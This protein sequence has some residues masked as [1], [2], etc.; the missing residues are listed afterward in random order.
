[1]VRNSLFRALVFSCLV[2]LFAF[3]TAD[4]SWAVELLGDPGFELSTPNGT[5]PDSGVWKKAWYPLNAGQVCTSTAAHTGRSGLWEYTAD[6][7]GLS[8]SGI[9][10]KFQAVAGQKATGS[11]WVRTPPAGLG[12]SW[13]NGSKACVRLE[14][15]DQ[16]GAQLTIHDS[17]CI[18]AAD[19]GWTPLTVTTSAAPAGTESVIFRCYV[20]KPNNGASVKSIANFDDCSLTLSEP[21][22]RLS[23]SP[24]VVGIRS[25][26]QLADIQTKK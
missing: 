14:F 18:T 3:L 9:Y 15:L 20:E 19:S 23:V 10:Q 4:V 17:D 12:G 25:A 5:F 24:E 16:S 1:M 8:W 13:S 2:M 11:A 7:G 6:S 26:S 22:G 21:Q